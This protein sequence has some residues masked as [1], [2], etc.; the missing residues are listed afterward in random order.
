MINARSFL[1]ATI[2]KVIG[3]DYGAIPT[4][5]TGNFP[6]RHQDSGAS[7]AC[8]IWEV[9][10]GVLIPILAGILLH[11]CGIHHAHIHIG[12]MVMIYALLAIYAI[13]ATPD[14]T[15]ANLET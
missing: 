11:A 8:Q 4:F 13:L 6:T 12:L 5:Y 10:G 14:T 9:Y 3:F 15:G 1:Y 2:G 7:A